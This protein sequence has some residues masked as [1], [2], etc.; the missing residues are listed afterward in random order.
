MCRE[1]ASLE[2][3]D[4]KPI[5]KPPSLASCERVSACA[6]TN[7]FTDGVVVFPNQIFIATPG[8]PVPPHS[9]LVRRRNFQEVIKKEKQEANIVDANPEMLQGLAQFAISLSAGQ[10][11]HPLIVLK[12]IDFYYLA[13]DWMLFSTCR[14]FGV[15]I[16]LH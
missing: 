9:L 4:L 8:H 12:E 10:S 16:T 1:F 2:L 13:D 6:L 11:L 14:N 3:Q 5:P 15:C 7:S